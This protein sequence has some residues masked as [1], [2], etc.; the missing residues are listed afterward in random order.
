M[1]AKMN[2]LLGRNG[3]NGPT[4]SQ[5]TRGTG[6]R[7]D[8]VSSRLEIQNG[9]WNAENVLRNLQRDDVGTFGVYGGAKL[10][11][12]Y[13]PILSVTHRRV[14]GYE[15]LLRPFQNDGTQTDAAQFLASSAA[16]GEQLIVDRVSRAAHVANYVSPG[17][18]AWLFLNMHPDVFCIGARHGHFAAGLLK[19]FGIAPEQ[20]VL[21]LLEHQSYDE[22]T[23][24][25][26]AQ[27]YR[28]FGFLLAIDDFGSGQSNFD[29]VWNLRPDFVK[30][31]RSLVGRAE[32][33]VVNQ[34]MVRH[35]VGLLHQA[36]A[37]VIAEGVETR[38]QALVMMEADVDFLQ[39]YWLGRP[40]SAI[41][42]STA[43][44][45]VAR[46][47]EAWAE[48][49]HYDRTLA[50]DWQ[51]A[52]RPYRRALHAAG[53]GF[54]PAEEPA[55]VA[56]LFFTCPGSL[57]FFVLNEAG[58]ME[59]PS[60]INPARTRKF[61]PSLKPLHPDVG[62]NW[63]RRS[64]F[65]EAL[66]NVGKTVIVGPHYS[67]SDGEGCYTAALAVPSSRGLLVLCGDFELVA[68]RPAGQT[69]EA[70]TQLLVV[71]DGE[72]LDAT[73]SVIGVASGVS[74]HL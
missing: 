19:H 74:R 54:A 46:L 38:R 71:S 68:E 20:I 55:A 16:R 61:K 62:G 70:G 43:H 21:E 39:G 45:A 32:D 30:L 4:G 37:M 15:A 28:D 13:Q 23:F 3:T 33:S 58:I 48:F 59:Q 12:A 34:R 57:R 24:Q 51:E 2:E 17:Q 40:Q 26:A 36:G 18:D 29:R 6:G 35:M 60:I 47:D 22:T 64:Y 31:D 63:S 41:L 53:R 73:R 9:D 25:E 67:L 44:A 14:V 49:G 1:G 69:T 27:Y 72:G 8:T 42:E 7:R 65:K 11:S 5:G 10:R 52:L 50:R 56:Q 66:K